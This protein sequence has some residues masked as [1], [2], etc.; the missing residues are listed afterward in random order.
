MIKRFIAV[1]LTVTFAM[2]AHAD[3]APTYDNA[4]ECI[5]MLE[6]LVLLTPADH[7]MMGGIKKRVFGWADYAKAVKPADK[8]T[9]LTDDANFTRDYLI[10]V[11]RPQGNAALQKHI[12]PL[13]KTC[14]VPP[15]APLPN[16]FE[17]ATPTAQETF[18]KAV[19]CA[20]FYQLSVDFGDDG[21]ELKRK[22]FTKLAQSANPS[23]QAEALEGMVIDQN[24][25]HVT[26]MIEENAK[27]VQ[28]AQMCKSA[29]K[30]M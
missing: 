13:Q 4:A 1:L 10:N 16:P 30:K 11:V 22:V 24:K 26:M 20:G 17:L 23:I 3:D 18:A 25:N 28:V 6:F 27:S 7:P 2:S 9:R 15:I 12:G 29:L 19:E 5:G 14:D 8:T 21:A